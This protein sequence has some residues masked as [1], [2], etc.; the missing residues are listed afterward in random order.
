MFLT[1]LIA[2]CNLSL[3]PKRLPLREFLSDRII[4]RFSEIIP[5]IGNRVIF[6][7]FLGG[8]A[9]AFPAYI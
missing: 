3:C 1:I 5:R 2:I 6:V 7:A 4:M 9:P 8:L